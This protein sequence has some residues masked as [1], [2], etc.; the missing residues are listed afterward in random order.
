VEDYHCSIGKY[1]QDYGTKD[2]EYKERTNKIVPNEYGGFSLIVDSEIIFEIFPYWWGECTCG[3]E[4]ENETLY[5]KWREELFTSKEWKDYTTIEYWC[6]NDCP[7]FSFNDNTSQEELLKYCTCGTMVKNIK[8][9]K[10][11][12]KI[13]DK[14]KEYEKRERENSLSHK[15]DCCLVKHNFVYHPNKDDCF[16]IDWYKYPFRDSYSN[17]NLSNN[18]ILAIFKECGDLLEKYILEIGGIY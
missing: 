12:D 10:R 17:K 6:K 16:S 3:V 15:D 14:I 1:Y 8:I 7:A 2:L 18:E 13:K 11:K 4:E 5:Q 9:K